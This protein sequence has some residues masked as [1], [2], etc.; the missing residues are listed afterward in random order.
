MVSAQAISLVAFGCI[1]GGTLLGMMLRS[2]LPEH[3]LSEESK[4][5]VKLGA[6]MIATLAALVLGLMIASAK[7]NFDTMSVELKQSGSKIILLD[8]TLAQYGPEAGEVRVLLRRMVVSVIQSVWPEKKVSSAAEKVFEPGAGIEAIQKKLRA[9]KPSDEEQRSLQSR[10]LQLSNDVAEGRWLMEEQWKQRSLPT[11]F[12]VMLVF[13]LTI[14]FTSFGLLS[15]RNATVAIVLLVCALS[16]SGSL[17]LIEE[18]DHPYE[19]F[20][21]ISGAPLTTALKFL[22]R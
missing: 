22:G 2:I 14:I 20:I 12:L 18:L 7:G 10:A 4:E 11:P 19:G 6:G 15:P 5:V 16:A 3:H 21:K 9:L 1:F 13:W 8:R 17:F